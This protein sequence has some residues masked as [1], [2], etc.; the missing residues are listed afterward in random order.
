MAA[1]TIDQTRTTIHRFPHGFIN[2]RAEPTLI[3]TLTERRH[4]QLIDMY[5]AFQ[6]RNSFSGLPPIRDEACVQWVQ[7]MIATGVSLVALSF[8]EGMV[9]HGALFPVSDEMCELL[10]VVRP[11]HQ[12]A[13]I[14][15]QLARCLIQVGH[16]LG[17]E[18]I[19]LSVEAGNHI[20]RHVY[21]KSGFQYLSQGMTDELEMSLDLDRYRGA[22]DVAVGEIMDRHVIV[23]HPE[24]PCKVALM[25]FLQDNVDAIPVVEGRDQLVGILS[26]ADLMVEENLDRK[27]REV[28]TREVVALEE[29][30]T[31]AKAIS[32]FR[33]R[34][35]RCIPV[36]NRRMEVVGVVR[37]KDILAHYL[38]RYGERVRQIADPAVPVALLA[39]GEQGGAGA[40]SQAWRPAEEPMIPHRPQ[41]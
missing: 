4:R 21:E 10:L 35:L 19:R 28:Q 11:A 16:E 38:R 13:G 39:T 29:T 30:C 15:G 8:E 5:L 31:V 12:G 26:E 1:M 2:K 3:T 17:F 36:L 20:A 27:V 6:P 34:N 24:M 25:I 41:A 7:G 23:L 18:R 9:A 37:R 33:S 40:P 32:L 22:V 14:G